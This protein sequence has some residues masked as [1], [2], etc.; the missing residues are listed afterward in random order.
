MD[1]IAYGTAMYNN[2][3]FGDASVGRRVIDSFAR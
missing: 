3:Q 1:G 2:E